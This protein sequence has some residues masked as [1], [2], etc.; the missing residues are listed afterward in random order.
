[1][2]KDFKVG[3]VVGLAV[4]VVLGALL[5][6]R[7]RATPR[8]SSAQ[9]QNHLMRLQE[10]NQTRPAYPAGGF[11]PYAT[12]TTAPMGGPAVRTEPNTAPGQAPSGT[13]YPPPSPIPYTP[14]VSQ[15]VQA[16]AAPS[17]PTK[18]MRVHVVAEDE[19]LSDIADHY[20]GSSDKWVKIHR[21]NRSTIKDPDRIYPGM[22]L[23]IPD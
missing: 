16:A 5:F 12:D 18:P 14:Q 19:T 11:Q 8:A 23:V 1:M 15:P 10:P 4:V 6:M 2:N 13:A 9:T 22:K 20:Y 17:T 7:G 21:A 3:M